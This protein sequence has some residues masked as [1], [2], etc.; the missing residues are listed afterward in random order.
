MAK[1]LPIFYNALLLTGVN[2]LLR[3]AGT[4]FQVYLS[5]K[6]GAEGI[7]LLQLVMS[8]GSLALTV[9]M[10]GIRT[11]TMYLCAEVVGQKQSGRM[12]W[13]LS[14][15]IVYSISISGA[16][17]FLLY[18]FAPLIAAGWIGNPAVSS[19]IRLFSAFLPVSC[20]CGVM[21]GY[22]TGINR[23]GTLAVVEVAEQIC[24][25]AAT[26]LLLQV[27]A[28][29]DAARACQCVILGSSIGACLTLLVLTALKHRHRESLGEHLPIR[30]RLWETA[31]PLAVADTAKAGI[32]T[33]E[34][35]MV[36][37]R[38]ALYPGASAPLAQFGMVCG[39]VFPVLMFP[40]AILFGLAELLIP[41]MA[42]CNA[43]GSRNRIRYLSERSLHLALLYGCLCGGILFIAADPLCDRL[44]KTVEAGQY[45]KW[46]AALAPMLYCDAITDAITKGLGKQSICVRYN[47]ITSAMDVGLLFVLLPKFGIEGYFASFF[48]THLI[49]FILSFRL[50]TK[51]VDK[52]L[53]MKTVIL[54]LLAVICSIYIANYFENRLHA[55]ISFILLFGASMVLLGII[56][57]KDC[58]WIIG[59]SKP[60][61]EKIDKGIS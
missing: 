18:Q 36:P 38:L 54:C 39:M 59:L 56:K 14:G 13:V 8:V 7:G 32:N 9:G 17:S 44:Y 27:W 46:F 45:L 3:F 52:I 6:I 1:K 10:G 25:M 31:V 20:L 47:I 53:P 22:Y 42:R 41:E 24:S 58:V 21:V 48:I 33:T 57:W 4:S 28:G 49:N 35:L 30:K 60:R 61:R 11:A 2:L 16:A 29:S 40:A 50:L 37:K 23:I 5:G 26:I 55:C 15:C 19:A 51:T 43:A 12:G 34:N